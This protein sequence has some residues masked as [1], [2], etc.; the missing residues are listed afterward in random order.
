MTTTYGNA[1]TV[2][3]ANLKLEIGTIETEY[4]H[5]SYSTT[6]NASMLSGNFNLLLNSQNEQS[7]NSRSAHL[8]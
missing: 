4:N 5:F 3:I 8:L 6:N 7:G 2:Y 1:G